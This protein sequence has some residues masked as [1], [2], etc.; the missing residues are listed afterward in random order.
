MNKIVTILITSVILICLLFFSCNEKR[1]IVHVITGKNKIKKLRHLIRKQEVDGVGIHYYFIY[2]NNGLL[3][4]IVLEKSDTIF[5]KYFG[6]TLSVERINT[7]T[8]GAFGDFIFR[9]LSEK[10]LIVLNKDSTIK[11]ELTFTQPYDI[12]RD[13]I[14]KNKYL[15]KSRVFKKDGIY[16]YKMEYK[17]GNLIHQEVISPDD[18]IETNDYVYDLERFNTT[19]IDFE[20]SGRYLIERFRWGISNRNV[21]VKFTQVN[22]RKNLNQTI[23]FINEFDNEGNIIRQVNKNKINGKKANIIMQYFYE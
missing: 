5:Y 7:G 8:D 2:N 22:K 4:K 21:L 19:N 3:S 17:N 12:Y 1:N 11:E 13:N 9:E 16:I 18:S 15:L 6:D 14:Y 23:E 10:V 20:S